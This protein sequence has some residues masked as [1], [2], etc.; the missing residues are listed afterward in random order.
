MSMK[1]VAVLALAS[2][3][4]SIAS[5]QTSGSGSTT[6]YWDCCKPSCGWSGKAAVSAPVAQCDAKGNKLTAGDDTQKNGCEA[7][8]SAFMCNDQTPWEVNDNLAY[9]FAAVKLAGQP[10]SASCC[11]CYELTFTSGPVSGKKMIVQS[12]NT[13]GDLGDNHFDLAIPGGGLGIFDGCSKSV[14]AAAQGQRYGGISDASQCS[15]WGALSG[16]CNFRFRWFQNADNPTIDWKRVACPAELTARTGCKRDDDSSAAPA[17]AAPA[18]APSSSSYV[19]P[20]ETT[21]A[22]SA[23]ASTTASDIISAPAG[24]LPVVTEEPVT[25]SST[26]GTTPAPTGNAAC[27]Q[28]GYDL[29]NPPTSYFDGSGQFATFDTC[30]TLC[31]QQTAQ[32]FGFGNGQCL[33]YPAPIAG[34]INPVAD[35]PITFYDIGCTADAPVPSDTT[36]AAPTATPTSSSTA[37]P[38]PTSSGAVSEPT[39]TEYPEPTATDVSPVPTDAPE[40]PTAAP[41]C[42]VTYV[43]VYDDE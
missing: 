5:A 23:P 12:T 29:Q 24:T 41:A 17:P 7:N 6:R 9:G 26:T 11:A 19:A 31:T 2:G 33:C 15:S 22:A 21:P 28:K 3:F 18:P 14:P 25:T 35:S 30:K 10:E 36:T 20:A 27:G 38:V 40:E 42:P 1:T 32:S 16:G 13:G 39:G 4:A 34:N 43:T 8:G 37:A